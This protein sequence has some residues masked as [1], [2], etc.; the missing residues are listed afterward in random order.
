[1]F[2]FGY[3]ILHFDDKLLASVYGR[4]DCEAI[5]EI[6]S[7]YYANHTIRDKDK[8]L[9]FQIGDK[10]CCTRNA[11]VVDL[12]TPKPVSE[13][14]LHDSK[15]KLF[16]EFA[17]IRLCNGEIFFIKNVSIATMLPHPR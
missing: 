13:D 11:T 4:C 2:N 10:V 14:S 5:N 9:K 1:L 12:D 3:A 7:K 16:E 8:R 15:K 17:P 6:C